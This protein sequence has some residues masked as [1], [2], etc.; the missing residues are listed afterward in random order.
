MQVEHRAGDVKEAQAL[1]FPL[2]PLCDAQRFKGLK[3]KD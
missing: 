1:V 3:H 2:E